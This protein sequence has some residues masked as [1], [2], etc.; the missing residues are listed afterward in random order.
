MKKWV[1]DVIAAPVKKSLPLLSF[2]SAAL[3]DITVRELVSDS[4]LQAEGMRLV[5]ERVPSAASV[6]LMDLSVEAEAFGAPIHVSENEVPTVVGSI[7][8]D[9]DEANELRIPEIGEGRTS[10]YIDAIKKA[11]SIINDRPVFAGMIGPYSL[12]GRLLDVSEAMILCYEEPETV[13]TVLEKAT[14]FL[15]AY[16]NAFKNAGANGI[17]IA[18]PLAGML[19]PGLASEFSHPYVKRIVDALSSEDFAVFYHNCGNNIALMAKDI[20]AIGA[21]GYHFGDAVDLSDMF[22]HAP[23]NVL[24]MG[25]VSPVLQFLKGTPESMAEET[26]RIMESLGDH[27]NFVISGGCDIPPASPWENIDAHFRAVS[28]FYEA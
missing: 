4:T 16:G 21:D 5:A 1:A 3:M 26:K 23:E 13:E 14:E 10:L 22:P 28:E 7:V 24:V 12:A 18:E 17:V 11:T 6:S 27:P 19:S 8:S 9:E 25:N 2:P 20:Y 15:I